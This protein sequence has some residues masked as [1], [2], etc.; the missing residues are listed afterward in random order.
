MASKEEG[1]LV[2]IGALFEMSIRIALHGLASVDSLYGIRGRVIHII[3]DTILPCD[4]LVSASVRFI[5]C[6]GA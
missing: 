6:N 1:T 3:V 4:L 5:N 2:L